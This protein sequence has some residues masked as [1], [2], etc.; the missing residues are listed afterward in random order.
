MHEQYTNEQLANMQ[1][2]YYDGKPTP[3][4]SAKFEY[5]QSELLRE[6]RELNPTAKQ[7]APCYLK[8][9]IERL[10]QNKQDAAKDQIA[11]GHAA[12]Q[13]AHNQLKNWR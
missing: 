7:A 2:I 8:A 4:Q 6:L 11:A 13:T 5:I 12:M 9:A 3:Y 1:K 10:L